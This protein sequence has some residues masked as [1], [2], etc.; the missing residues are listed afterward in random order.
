MNSRVSVG[1][2][3]GFCAS[4]ALH[5]VAYASLHQGPRAIPQRDFVSEVSIEVRP[6]PT[7]ASELKPE[8][9][10]PDLPA[11]HSERRLP[12]A[13]HPALAVRE[14]SSPRPSAPTTAA[15][16]LSGVT[17]TNDNGPAFSMPVG[18]GGPLRAG[19]GLAQQRPDSAAPSSIAPR[20]QPNGPVPISDL[21]EHPVPPPLAGLLRANY[22][23][24]ARQRGLRGS[25]RVRARIDPDGVTRSA[26]VVF[27][28]A[29]GFGAAC[30]RTLLGSH[31]SPPRAKNGGAVATEIV[32]VCHFE[33]DQ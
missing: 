20:T 12:T 17:L 19:F 22:P 9:P 7:V 26:Q 25:A 32:Y 8:L 21:S 29:A 2:G 6:R 16:D 4:V 5:G 14:S 13:R 24:E 15:L 3:L 27:E 23:D 31:W 30:R 33:V 11:K 10:A 1:L 18:D 28:S